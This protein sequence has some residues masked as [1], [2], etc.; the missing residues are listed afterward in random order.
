LSKACNEL[1]SLTKKERET[2]VLVNMGTV[3]EYFDF[4][5]YMHIAV[6]L[7]ATFFPTSDPYTNALLAAFSFSMGYILRPIGSFIFGILGDWWGRKTNILITTMAMSI[8]SFFLGCM[9]TYAQAGFKASIAVIICRAIQG[10]CSAVEII[11]A[12]VYVTETLK[13]PRSYFFGGMT[14]LAAGIGELLALF[15]CSALIMLRPEDGWRYVF[16]LGSGLAVLGMIART[17]LRETPEFIKA[18]SE[19]KSKKQNT[20]GAIVKTLFQHKRNAIAYLLVGLL[21]PFSFFVSF[22]YMGTIL[23][24]NYGYTP[25]NLMPHNL[26]ITVIDLIVYCGMLFLTLYYN[27][28]KIMKVVAYLFIATSALVPFVVNHS[29]SVFP[30]FM[31][32]SLIAVFSVSELGLGVFARGFPVVGRYTLLGVSYSLA[33]ALAAVSTSYGC[34]YVGDRYGIEGV[35]VL[36]I[37][38]ACAHL[39][40]LYLFVPCEEDKTFFQ[41]KT[42]PQT[43]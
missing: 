32:Q 41:A 15:C 34:V 3:L 37:L 18:S 28:L 25:E 27:P 40:G 19:F 22:I 4:K 24:S 12:A 23:T 33:R 20:K 10:I 8:S 35:S 21:T 26:G 11:G 1:K 43:A 5:T 39:I 9:P 42:L 29:T 36:L 13:P 16:F 7:N 31:M 30:I 6:I 38:I 14:G 17:R 2:L